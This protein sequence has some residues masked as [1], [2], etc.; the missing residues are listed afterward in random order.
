MSCYLVIIVFKY[1]IR[2]LLFKVAKALSQSCLDWPHRCPVPQGSTGTETS[3]QLP[4]SKVCRLIGGFLPNGLV[5]ASVGL[6]TPSQG[7]QSTV[8]ELSGLATQLPGPSGVDRNRNESTTSLVKGVTLDWRIPGEWAGICQCGP[9][10][11][12][13]LRQGCQSTVSELSGLAAPLPGP[14]GVDRNRNKPITSLVKGVTLDWRIPGEWVGIC[15]C[16]PVDTESGLPKHCVSAVWT[17]RTAARSVRG[18]QE[19][20]RVNNTLVTL[21]WRIPGEWAGICQ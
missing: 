20:K 8:S 14:S 10:D 6:L 17:G 16:G 15:Q 2:V 11:T 9:V 3:Q 18:R 19:Q 5:S 13:S 12:E 1:L 4:W 21:D 7:C